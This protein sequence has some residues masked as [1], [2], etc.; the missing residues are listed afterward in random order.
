MNAVYGML[1]ITIKTR[2][3][4]ETNL[5]ITYSS[6]VTAQTRIHVLTI[7]NSVTKLTEC[8]YISTKQT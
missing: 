8:P 6:T 1:S 5:K 2:Q 7:I 3:T 4:V